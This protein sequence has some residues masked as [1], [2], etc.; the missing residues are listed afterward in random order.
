MPALTAL[1][2]HQLQALLQEDAPYGDLT[3][4]TLG[5]GAQAASLT[6]RA[7]QPMTVCATEAA[8]RPRAL[9]A[10][11]L[12]QQT[13]SVTCLITSLI[14]LACKCGPIGKLST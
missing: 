3:T 10:D 11:V 7:R 2:D 8:C 5:L 12:F 9:A 14:E 1:S 13:A 6:F 4:H